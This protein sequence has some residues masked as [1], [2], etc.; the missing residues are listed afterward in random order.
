MKKEWTIDTCNNEDDFQNKYAEWKNT[1]RV[2]TIWFH[3]YKILEKANASI[4]T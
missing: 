4:E 2:Q 3:L 1:K